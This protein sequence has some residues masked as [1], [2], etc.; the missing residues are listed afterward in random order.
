LYI[1][2]TNLLELPDFISTYKNLTGLDIADLN[3]DFLPD[4]L[5]NDKILKV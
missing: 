2:S 1:N 4:W 3:L 5:S